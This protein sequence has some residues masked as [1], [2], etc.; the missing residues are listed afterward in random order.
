MADTGDARE[1]EEGG[2]PPPPPKPAAAK[3]APPPPKTSPAGFIIGLLVGTLLA[4]GGGGFFGL[5]I[6]GLVAKV[7]AKREAEVPLVNAIAK[8]VPAGAIVKNLP[9]VITNLAAPERT[10]LR[11]EGAIIVEA[12]EVKQAD[13]LAAQISEDIIAFLRTTTLT[14]LQGPSGYQHLR[15]DLTE[16]VRV[17]SGGRVRDLLIQTLIFE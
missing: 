8:V 3:A 1:G 17:R 14:Q 13:I 6:A 16:R 9:P 12:P 10:W 2:A 4:V 11:L 15:E 7:A 5:Q